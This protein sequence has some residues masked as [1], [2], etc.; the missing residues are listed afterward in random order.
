MGFALVLLIGTL[1]LAPL[2]HWGQQISEATGQIM[3][4]VVLILVILLSA[5][6]FLER[7]A[8]RRGW[9]ILPLNLGICAVAFLVARLLI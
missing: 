9:L 7:S 8:D 4:A 2:Q 1:I 6:G 3:E 5:L